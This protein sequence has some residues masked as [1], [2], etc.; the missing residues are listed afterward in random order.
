GN[1]VGP[2]R[3]GTDDAVGHHA[4]LAVA[5]VRD[6]QVSR[7]VHRYVRGQ[8][9]PG[10]LR[11]SAVATVDPGQARAGYSDDDAVRAHTAYAPVESVRDV[12]VPGGVHRHALGSVQGRVD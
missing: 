12:Q 1:A 7:A 11:R 8:R 4:H 5:E 6:I 2:A 9:D 3:H 10:V